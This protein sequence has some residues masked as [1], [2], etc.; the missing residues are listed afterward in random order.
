MITKNMSIEEVIKKYPDTIDIF[1]EFGLDCFECQGAQYDNI[2]R[3]AEVH[4]IDIDK[5]LMALN[6]AIEEKE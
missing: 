2:E 4:R 6:K 5:L 3:G 1:L